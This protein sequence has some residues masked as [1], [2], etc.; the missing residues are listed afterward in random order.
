MADI[1]VG[2]VYHMKEKI[3]GQIAKCELAMDF[4]NIKEF[5]EAGA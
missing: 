3:L 2:T 5:Q 1:R 4:A